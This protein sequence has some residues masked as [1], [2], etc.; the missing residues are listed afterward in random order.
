MAQ[1]FNI[2]SSKKS[3]ECLDG[4]KRKLRRFCTREVHQMTKRFWETD[5]LNHRGVTSQLEAFHP[6]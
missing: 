2:S 6:T 4:L 5:I 3:T 1:W